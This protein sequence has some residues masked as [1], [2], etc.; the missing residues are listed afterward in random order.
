MLCRCF[1][2]CRH[3]LQ[4]VHGGMRNTCN[5]NCALGHHRQMLVAAD[6]AMAWDLRRGRDWRTRSGSGFGCS[7]TTPSVGKSCAA[8]ACSAR[9]LSLRGSWS[10]SRLWRMPRLSPLPTLPRRAARQGTMC[11]VYI[12]ALMPLFVVGMLVGHTRDGGQSAAPA[13]APVVGAAGLARSSG[14]VDTV[15]AVFSAAALHTESRQRA[16][17]LHAAPRSLQGR[18]KHGGP[19]KRQRN[20]V[21]ASRARPLDFLVCISGGGCNCQ[22]V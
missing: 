5:L 12:G 2:R 4:R 18:S 17:A 20:D 19:N 1:T 9:Q 22:S 3:S 16:E 13:P 8:C 21:I 14:G 15:R 7:S 10:L 11:Y 6:R